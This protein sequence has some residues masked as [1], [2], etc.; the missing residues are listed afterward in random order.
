M[1]KGIRLPSDLEIVWF[2]GFFDGE[3]SIQIVFHKPGSRGKRATYN[4][5][6]SIGNTY[7]PVIKR[8]KETWNIGHIGHDAKPTAPTHKLRWIWAASNNEALYIL[9]TILPYLLVKGHEARVGIVFQENK[10]NS[11][12]RYGTYTQPN[13]A[14]EKD[15]KFRDLLQEMKGLNPKA[16]AEINEIIER[17]I[18]EEDRVILD[19]ETKRFKVVRGSI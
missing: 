9:K 15:R 4:L 1:R 2:A 3:G 11:I 10:R 17:L 7:L 5:R 18:K 12:E 6:I 14:F 19:P 8:I 13:L 16:E